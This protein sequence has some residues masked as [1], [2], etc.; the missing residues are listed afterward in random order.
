M[1]SNGNDKSRQPFLPNC[2]RARIIC[3]ERI[4]ILSFSSPISNGRAF[5]LP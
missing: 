5:F 2:G 1:N 3:S 4:S